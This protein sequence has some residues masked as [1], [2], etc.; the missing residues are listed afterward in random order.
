MAELPA[1]VVEVDCD[2]CAG[3]PGRRLGGLA[4]ETCGLK[5]TLRTGLGTGRDAVP[6][7]GSRGDDSEAALEDAIVGEVEVGVGGRKVMERCRGGRDLG[8]WESNYR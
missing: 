7:E 6:S 3:K 2:V 4:V 8:Q 1:V 5:V